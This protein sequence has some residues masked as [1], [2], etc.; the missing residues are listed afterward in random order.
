MNPPRATATGTRVARTP[1][2]YGLKTPLA[3]GAAMLGSGT[4][5]NVAR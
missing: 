3:A 2:V 4:Q 1:N 5:T